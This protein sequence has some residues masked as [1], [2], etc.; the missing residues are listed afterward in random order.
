MIKRIRTASSVS[1]LSIQQRRKAQ[2]VPTT[3][4]QAPP[5]L[6]VAA[7][8]CFDAG[9]QLCIGFVDVLYDLL[10]LHIDLLDRLLLLHNI[11][12]DLREE[13]CEFLHLPF[14]FLNSFVAALD[15]S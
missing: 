1:A 2:G 14:Y 11:F 3:D 12:I 7:S 4:E 9:V 5:F 10:A 8:G 6:P 15:R 13:L